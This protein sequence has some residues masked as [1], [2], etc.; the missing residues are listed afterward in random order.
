MSLY[1]RVWRSGAVT[2]ACLFLAAP[3]ST[4]VTGAVIP[5][6]GGWSAW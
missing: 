2:L 1:R 4:Y 3:A 5:V 6:D